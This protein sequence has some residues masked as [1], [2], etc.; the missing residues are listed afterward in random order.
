MPRAI[1]ALVLQERPHPV[2]GDFD[3]RGKTRRSRR[4]LFPQRGRAPFPSCGRSVDSPRGGARSRFASAR[5]AS[6]G[7]VTVSASAG[8]PSVITVQ[9]SVETQRDRS[10]P[11]PENSRAV[12][13]RIASMSAAARCA[14]SAAATR[15][16]HSGT[17][18]T[19]GPVNGGAVS[20]GT[21]TGASARCAASASEPPPMR[22]V[23]QLPAR[24]RPPAPA[25]GWHGRGSSAG[26]SPGQRR[27]VPNAPHSQRPPL[28]LVPGGRPCVPWPQAT[29]GQGS[30]STPCRA[31]YRP[32]VGDDG[33]R[34]LH[35]A[36]RDARW[37]PASGD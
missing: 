16:T 26:R 15:A 31:R 33:A 14:A 18:T 23:R 8:S 3:E 28:S 12:R 7:S 21:S 13:A 27:T 20:R 25:H 2:P 6:I 1:W 30:R 19:R 11:S 9:S 24:T 35:G 10:S 17:G 37:L 4:H 22:T 36:H 32:V 5:F 29:L 34:P